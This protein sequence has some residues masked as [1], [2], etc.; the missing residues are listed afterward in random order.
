MKTKIATIGILLIV[1]FIAGIILGNT[2]QPKDETTTAL[3]QSELNAE[4]FLI[5][6]ELFD[7]FETTCDVAEKR[8]TSLSEQLWTLGK[9]LSGEDAKAQL[10][11]ETYHYLKLK[12][13][14]MQIRTYVLEKN[15]HDDC[16]KPLNV[17]LYYYA[18]NE[19]SRQQGQILDEL[20][21]ARNIHIF[22]IEH[23]YSKELAFMEDYYSLTTAPT[24]IINFNTT[25]TGLNSQETIIPHLYD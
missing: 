25:L 7:T 10:G 14:L 5:E 9:S 8:L 17:I 12:Y 3:Q 21:A 22:A 13:H 16:H 4:S 15:L 18:Q 1:V 19:A 24:L 20:A 2:Y 23:Q 6:Q 11:E